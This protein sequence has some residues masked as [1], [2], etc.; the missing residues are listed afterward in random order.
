M[1]KGHH[2]SYKIEDKEMAKS[3]LK[4]PETVCSERP[5]TILDVKGKMK[6][7]KKDL[8]VRTINNLILRISP[9]ARK[10]QKKKKS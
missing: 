5:P 3:L 8:R 4:Q 9:R 6:R 2:T 10:L 1:P 7:E